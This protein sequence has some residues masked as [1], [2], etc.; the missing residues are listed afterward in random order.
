MKRKSLITA[1]VVALI[2]TGGVVL[3]QQQDYGQGN[4]AWGQGWFCPWC[5]QQYGQGMGPGMMHRGQGMRQG[6]HDQSM[7][8]G[9]GSCEMQRWQGQGM[10][11]GKMR[12]YQGR[13]TRHGGR[14]MGRCMR[15]DQWSRGQYGPSG[16]QQQMEPLTQGKARNLAEDYVA[17][18]P[19][20]KSH[21][22][23]YLYHPGSSLAQL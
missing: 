1:M 2:V 17:G 13:S 7:P 18:N 6:W 4:V 12:G 9:K 8:Q 5:G 14:G 20:L 10:G 23:K 15:G 21:P 3:A 16:E 22:K 11:P 19:N